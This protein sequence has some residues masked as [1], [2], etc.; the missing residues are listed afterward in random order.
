MVVLSGASVELTSTSSFCNSCHIMNPYYASWKHSSHK[1]V[2]CVQCHIAPGATN[3]M[4]AKLNGL[5][6]VVDDV[7]HRTSTKPSASVS[8]MSCT[9]G[10]CHTVETLSA[11]KIDNGR[12]KFAHDKHLG[13]KHLGVEISCTTCHSHV[14]GDEHFAVNTNACLTCHMVGDPVH[15]TEV[16]AGREEAS[17]TLAAR[18]AQS[19]VT[20]VVLEGEKT[21]PSACTTCHDAPNKEI[22]FGG[23]KFNHSQFLSFGASCESCHQGTTA[24]PPPIEDGRCLECHTFGVERAGDSRELHRT[25]TLG[26]HKV[27]CSSCHGTIRHGLKVQTASL[28]KFDC[29]RCHIDQHTVQRNTYFSM[30]KSPHAKDEGM[31]KNVMFMAHVDCTGC[32]TQPRAV[33]ARPGGGATVLV[34]SPESCDKCHQPGLGK[35]M[36]PLW[37]RTAHG[38]F[39]Q[40]EGGYKAAI[41]AGTP[42]E[43]LVK[44]KAVL[45]EVRADGSW[46]VHNPTRTQELLAAA[47]DS[48]AAAVKPADRRGAAAP[49]PA[50]PAA[51][52]ALVGDAR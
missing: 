29:N 42:V 32:H 25:H 4:A 33:A 30:G 23:V 37:Q 40:V 43:S 19:N 18:S 10:G 6:Q 48:L 45:D 1:G 3:F 17:I 21:P 12:F 15:G 7:L 13:Q 14:K 2:E 38:L 36:I 31:T 20:P 51:S 5:G 49:A 34:A 24:T 16:V 46:G 8:Q 27:E 28:E 35:Q 41:E 26:E 50:S 39:D 22:E 9:R 11:K 47:R 52:A 44:V